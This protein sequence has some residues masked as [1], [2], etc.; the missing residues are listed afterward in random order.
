MSREELLDE[1]RRSFAHFAWTQAHDSLTAADRMH[2]LDL[3]DLE[4]AAIAAHLAGREADSAAAWMR[5]HAISAGHSD[6]GRAARCAFWLAFRLLNVGEEAQANGWATRAQRVL[7]GAGY[8]GVERGYLRYLAG[9]R[10]IFSGDAASAYDAFAESAMIGG[11]FGDLDLLT[12]ARH[13][14]GRAL[15]FLGRVTEGMTLLDEVM[16]AITA[17][18]VSPLVVGDTYC[19]VIEACQQILDIRRAQAWTEALHRWCGLQP[20]LVPYR[21]QCLIHRAEML[22]LRGA[23]REAADEAIRACRRLSDPP[24]Q[25][26]LGA[27]LYQQAELHRLHGECDAAEAGYRLANEAGRDPQPGLALLRLV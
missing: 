17:G 13:G 4:R 2:P 20:D 26:A 10:A 12:L 18:E 14:Q 27:A 19:S 25:L 9:L 8:D 5:A 24:G 3:D 1:G 21:G 23:W 7:D 15:I 22:Q 11:R 16:V 6:P